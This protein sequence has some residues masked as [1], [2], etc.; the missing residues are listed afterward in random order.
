MG[1][2][3]LGVGAV[4]A[5]FACLWDPSLPTGLL[6]LAL[7]VCA[8]YLYTMFGCYPWEVCCFLKVEGE[9]VQE[10]TGGRGVERLGRGEEKLQL[11]YSI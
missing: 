10:K 1:L 11:V 2:L 3:T 6:H 5:S 9:V 7:M 8:W 4:S